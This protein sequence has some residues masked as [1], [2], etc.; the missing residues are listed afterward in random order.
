MITFSSLTPC[1][2]NTSI[3]VIIVAPVSTIKD[4]HK[5]LN[6]FTDLKALSHYSATPIIKAH[7]TED[8]N[9]QCKYFPFQLIFAQSRVCYGNTDLNIKRKRV[10]IIMLSQN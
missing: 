3:A 8:V 7:C 5:V 10:Y 2:N 1:S 4:L 6:N 9:E